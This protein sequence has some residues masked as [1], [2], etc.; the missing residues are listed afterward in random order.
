VGTLLGEAGINI[1]GMHVGREA[2]GAR[3]IMALLVDE[4]IPAETLEEMR[5]IAGMETAQPVSL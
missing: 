2:A 5:A 4:P 3:A 1:A